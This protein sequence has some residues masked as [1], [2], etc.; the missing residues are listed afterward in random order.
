MAWG[1]RRAARAHSSDAFIECLLC[2]SHEQT[3]QSPATRSTPSG[4]GWGEGCRGQPQS[5]KRLPSSAQVLSCSHV[6]AVGARGRPERLQDSGHAGWPEGWASS[7]GVQLGSGWGH[8]PRARAAGRQEEAGHRGAGRGPDSCFLPSCLPGICSVPLNTHTR[9]QVQS[10]VFAGRPGT[11]AAWGHRGGGGPSAP[12][13]QSCGAPAQPSPRD[14]FPRS[15]L[16]CAFCHRDPWVPERELWR[17]RSPG[18]GAYSKHGAGGQPE[19]L[20][21]PRTQVGRRAPPPSSRWCR[22][23]SGVTRS[24]EEKQGLRGPRPS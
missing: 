18:P 9:A 4:V 3:G 16:S 10:P 6:V 11:A 14:P 15:P 8:R 2:A 23:H 7:G 12:P 21:R 13:G 19:L 20:L 1:V 17:P 22:R 5:L 24:Q